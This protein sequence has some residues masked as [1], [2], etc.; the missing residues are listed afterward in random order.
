MAP[1]LE[2][3]EFIPHF[4]AFLPYH[5]AIK[6]KEKKNVHLFISRCVVITERSSVWKAW[7]I[8]RG[9]LDLGAEKPS[10]V[11]EQTAAQG[12]APSLWVSS[13]RK[14]T[15]GGS[16]KSRGL[17]VAPRVPCCPG[18]GHKAFCSLSGG[19]GRSHLSG[20]TIQDSLSHGNHVL[21]GIGF[22]PAVTKST[23][24]WINFYG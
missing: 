20:I 10:K 18:H 17:L 14:C 1:G 5:A 15:A 9:N 16:Y 6:L 2:A 11:L 24:G 13:S 12:N 22:W 21:F 8:A 3:L 4:T 23:V 19:A 7:N